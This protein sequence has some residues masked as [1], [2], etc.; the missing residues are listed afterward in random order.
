MRT[1]A[2]ACSSFSMSDLL[3]TRS[4][5]KDMEEL[6][7]RQPSLQTVHKISADGRPLDIVLEK[8]LLCLGRCLDIVRPAGLLTGS[9]SSNDWKLANQQM[10]QAYS[11]IAAAC[12]VDR[13]LDPFEWGKLEDKDDPIIVRENAE[14]P[15]LPVVDGT[16]PPAKKPRRKRATKRQPPTTPQT[17]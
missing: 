8:T 13:P 15:A 3:V 1:H 16:S 10:Q 6:Y 5:V 9:V 7:H 2:V 17:T 4:L 11:L 14:P 12:D